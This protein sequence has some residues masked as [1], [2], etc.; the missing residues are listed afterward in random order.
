MIKVQHNDY[1][2]WDTEIIGMKPFPNDYKELQTRSIKKMSQRHLL[3]DKSREFNEEQKTIRILSHIS[4]Q[5]VAIIVN[6]NLEKK[7]P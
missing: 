5:Y 1:L 3:F 6:T 2:N 7:K 4:T